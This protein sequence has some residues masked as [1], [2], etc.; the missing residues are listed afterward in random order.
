LRD[1]LET[2]YN[3]SQNRV[4]RFED[5]YTPKNLLFREGVKGGCQIYVWIGIFFF[6][7]HSECTCFKVLHQSA[8]NDIFAQNEKKMLLSKIVKNAKIK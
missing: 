2:L 3:V 5:F 1:Y 6:F 7:D 8:F 4:K